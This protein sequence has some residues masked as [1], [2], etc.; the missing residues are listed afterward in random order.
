[1]KEEFQ[2]K[3]VVILQIVYQRDW[4]AYSSNRITITFDLANMGQP[5]NWCSIV[6]TQLLVELIH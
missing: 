3:F 2:A 6:L 5:I 1:M 4:L